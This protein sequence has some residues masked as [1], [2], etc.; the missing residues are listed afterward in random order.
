M[1]LAVGLK[2]KGDTGTKPKVVCKLCSGKHRWFSC[3]QYQTNA[4]RIARAGQLKLCKSC[5][6]SDH[7]G[8]NWA[9]ITRV[10]RCSR[11]AGR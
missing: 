2:N 4:A 7:R 6:G 10:H 1:N 5:L 11:E 8:N 3:L 9:T